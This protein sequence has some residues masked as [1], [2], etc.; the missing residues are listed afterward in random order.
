M[1][2]S[3]TWYIVT[4]NQILKFKLQKTEEKNLHNYTNLLAYYK[5]KFSRKK[6]QWNNDCIRCEKHSL[7]LM[8]NPKCPPLLCQILRFLI[9]WMHMVRNRSKPS[10][11]GAGPR[12]FPQISIQKI[13]SQSWHKHNTLLIKLWLQFSEWHFSKTMPANNTCWRADMSNQTYMYHE[14]H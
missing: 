12:E 14:S 7:P 11:K 6:N 2:I 10:S 3:Y 9:T 8:G 1:F 13:I 5:Y 4:S